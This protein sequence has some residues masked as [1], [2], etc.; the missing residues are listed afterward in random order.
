MYTVQALWSQAR[1]GLDVTTVVCANRSYRI[2]RV[3]LARAGIKDP[4][5]EACRLT[6]L[7]SPVIDWVA[8]AKSLGVPGA[9]VETADDLV[10][11]LERGLA[12][13]GPYLIEAVI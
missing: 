8:L 12:E 5:P 4:G 2:L 3:E 11:H 6:D 7:T 10:L 13:S 9:R 1:E